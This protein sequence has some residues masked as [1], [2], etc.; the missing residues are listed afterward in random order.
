MKLLA[1]IQTAATTSTEPLPDLL[2]RCKV[3]AATLKHT[4]FMA[5]TNRELNGYEELDPLPS[6]RTVV[7][8][9]SVGTYVGYGGAQIK[10]MPIPLY[11]IDEEVRRRVSY[12]DFRQG[13]RNIETMAHDESKLHMPWN[14]AFIHLVG[15]SI[16]PNYQLVTANILFPHGAFSGILDTIRTRV[17]D[18]VIAI[19]SEYPN[20]EDSEI[21]RP[22]PVP[23]SSITNVFHSTI[24][25]GHANIGTTGTASIKSGDTTNYFGLSPE[26]AAELGRVVNAARGEAER[27][28]EVDKKVA[29]ET[30]DE[31][32]LAAT[33]RRLD[34]ASIK[35]WTSTISTLISTAATTFPKLHALVHWLGTLL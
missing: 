31:V 28:P 1:D 5:W 17:L 33:S 15:H 6:Y 27:L 8:S 19:Q 16:I 14:P 2:R 26:K 3:L 10:N 35:K 7:S 30:I 23:H 34:V 21:G 29:L 12:I 32:A 4:E 11:E 18:F 20:I 25:G 24:I 22:S 9:G 13:V